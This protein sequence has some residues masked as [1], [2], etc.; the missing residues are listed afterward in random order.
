MWKGIRAL[1]APG[2]GWGFAMKGW[3]RGGEGDH[4]VLLDRNLFWLEKKSG[5]KGLPGR[6]AAY[7]ARPDQA[8]QVAPGGGLWPGGG[9]F[10]ARVLLLGKPGYRPSGDQVTR[11]TRWRPG[12]QVAPGLPGDQVGCQVAPGLPG[13]QVAAGDQAATRWAAVGQARTPDKAGQGLA[14]SSLD[15]CYHA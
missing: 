13:D 11:P 4:E 2:W 10:R 3:D 12:D 6:L 9:L 15:T 5:F 8:D 1:L 7:Q 14:Y